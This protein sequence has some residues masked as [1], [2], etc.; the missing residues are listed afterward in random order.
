MTASSA[1][2]PVVVV[3]VDGSESSKLALRWAARIARAEDAVIEIV[4]TWHYPYANGWAAV[5]DEYSPE[6]D[7]EK[8]LTDVVDEVFEGARPAD[9]RVSVLE[10]DPAR[11]LIKLSETA[12]LVVVGSRGRGGFAGVLLGSV[13]GKVSQL[14]KCPVLIAHGAHSEAANS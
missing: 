8:V 1:Q 11:L 6:E 5:P 2:R 3:G 9:L 13:S 4:G 14:A 7:L 10:G 12:L